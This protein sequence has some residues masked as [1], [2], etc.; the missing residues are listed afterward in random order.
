MLAF[1]AQSIFLKV[2]GYVLA[3]WFLLAKGLTAQHT[4][5]RVPLKEC[6]F[7]STPALSLPVPECQHL[8][9]LIATNDNRADLHV[10]DSEKHSRP[11]QFL[12][13]AWT[14]VV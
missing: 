14:F 7:F 5:S 12:A 13:S 11:D 1:P 8:V 4:A 6:L 9:E 10:L 2:A 3:A